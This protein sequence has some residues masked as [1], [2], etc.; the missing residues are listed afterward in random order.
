MRYPGQRIQKRI[1][2]GCPQGSICGPEFWNI[3]MEELLQDL[4]EVPEVEKALARH[5][6][7]RANAALSS[8]EE[9]CNAQKLQILIRKTTF[10][11]LR[12]SMQRS[13]LIKLGGQTL[14]RQMV[15]KYLGIHMAERGSFAEHITQTY[16]KATA[17][18]QKIARMARNRYSMPLKII[19]V[20][21][22]SVM[23]SIV[24]YGASVWT[25]KA[26]QIRPHQK[27]NAA[28][29]GV[30]ITLT[31]AY[32]TTSADALQVIAGVLP[33][34]LEVL[35]VAAEYFLRT[36]KMAKLEELFWARS[37][38]KRQIR[39]LLYGL[40][41][42]I[43]ESS[44]Q[45]RFVYRFLRDIRERMEMGHMDPSRGLTHFLAWHGPFPVYLH[46]RGLKE[47]NICDCRPVG[48][49]DYVIL[50]CPLISSVADEERQA[51]RGLE[52]EWALRRREHF[53]TLDRLATKVVNHLEGQ[54][55]NQT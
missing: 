6:E 43:W 9:W 16:Y 31:G 51:I 2:K 50:E 29:R 7:G 42:H 27:L 37:S 11:M 33:M 5:L 22:S 18:M 17:T 4:D 44:T 1:T 40:W 48:T 24:T 30:L 41:Q 10:T 15:T 34:D 3:T 23:T 47:T 13:P 38:S 55:L 46:E 14:R 28:Q 52:I 49:V 26:K 35:R 39:E 45:G 20:Y 54:Q 8:L 53:R 25:H 32:R 12:D 36:G 21:M 19:R